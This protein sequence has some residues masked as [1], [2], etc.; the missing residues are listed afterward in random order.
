MLTTD[1][2]PDRI[3]MRAY[4]TLTLADFKAFEEE[5]NY[6]IQFS[7]PIDVLL[8]L[9]NML[10]CSIDAALEELRYVRAHP[11][12][13]RRVAVLTSDQVVTWSTWLAQFFVDADIRVFDVEAEARQWLESADER[14]DKSRDSSLTH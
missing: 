2:L 3:E 4:G 14:S 1:L 10:T 5:S 12:D 11:A 8:D 13:F 9:R 7:G 6:R